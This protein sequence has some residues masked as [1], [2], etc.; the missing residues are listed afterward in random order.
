M[1]QRQGEISLP[2]L[3]L[4]IVFS[5]GWASASFAA[6]PQSTLVTDS[7]LDQTADRLSVIEPS[8][9]YAPAL[10]ALVPMRVPVGET[11]GDKQRGYI[12]RPV[13]RMMPNSMYDFSDS[14]LDPVGSLGLAGMPPSAEPRTLSLSPTDLVGEVSALFRSPQQ[15][16]STFDRGYRDAM[17][18]GPPSDHP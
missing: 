8:L 11:D 15:G 16:V 9:V 10:G 13:S 14:A 3:L 12:L 2:L 18:G 1:R 17:P 5:G 7:L 6:E 4:S